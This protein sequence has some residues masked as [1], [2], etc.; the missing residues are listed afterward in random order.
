MHRFK[1]YLCFNQCYDILRDALEKRTDDAD[2][3]ELLDNVRELKSVRRLDIRKE[4]ETER[5]RRSATVDR[6]TRKQIEMELRLT[7]ICRLVSM[8]D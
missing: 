6:A 8:M 3:K 5:M 4:A 1:K 2:Y 7:I